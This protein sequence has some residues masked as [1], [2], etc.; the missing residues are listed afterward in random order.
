[1]VFQIRRVGEARMMRDAV[2]LGKREAIVILGFGD[3]T[4]A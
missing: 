1:M 3:R 4:V 2:L